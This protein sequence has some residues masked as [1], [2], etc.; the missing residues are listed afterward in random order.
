MERGEPRYSGTAERVRSVRAP[1]QRALWCQGKQAAVQSG[2]YS[3]G[4][5]AE[6]LGGL[7]KDSKAAG[8][9]T[10]VINYQKEGHQAASVKKKATF[11]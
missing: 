4:G 11:G 6:C 7:T 1:A 10:V 3:N 5:V 2:Y 9:P 8:K